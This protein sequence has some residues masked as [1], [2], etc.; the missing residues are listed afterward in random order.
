MEV[1][2]IIEVIISRPRCSNETTMDHGAVSKIPTSNDFQGGLHLT[3]SRA[4][5][6]RPS[7]ELLFSTMTGN[8]V[9]TLLAVQPGESGERLV[10]S[11][12]RECSSTLMDFLGFI[13]D[14][15]YITL[16][17]YARWV[18]ISQHHSRSFLLC[19][20]GELQTNCPCLGTQNPMENLPKIAWPWFSP[21]NPMV[22]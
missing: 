5:L 12:H 3:S 16:L 1:S 21:Q 20:S 19:L 7:T 4:P 18:H 10:A 2:D 9:S 15:R 14:I 8:V 17:I 13:W 6:A 11:W 22:S